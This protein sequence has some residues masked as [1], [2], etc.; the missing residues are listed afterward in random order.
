[1][2]K[3]LSLSAASPPGTPR[4]SSHGTAV[5]GKAL[6]PHEATRLRQ[7]AEVTF[8]ASSR[9][10][11]LARLNPSGARASA[12]EA[13][14]EVE[15]GPQ[16]PFAAGLDMRDADEEAGSKRKMHVKK[17]EKKK[18]RWLAGPKAKHKQSENER[19]A[20]SAGAGS[21]CMGP[22]EY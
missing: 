10:Y 21:G 13:S 8:G 9:R 14:E 6:K 4:R 1:M 19:V 17:W 15:A 20:M 7:G 22:G 16:L 2:K 11:C 3:L 18:R 5:N 12:S